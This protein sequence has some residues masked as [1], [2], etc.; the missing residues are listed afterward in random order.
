MNSA[1][2]ESS[3]PLKASNLLR[4]SIY[5]R[6]REDILGCRMAPGEELR[7]QE[8]AVRFEVNVPATSAPPTLMTSPSG[9]AMRTPTVG[10]STSATRAHP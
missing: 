8:L 10:S 2:I 4:D 1:S 7:E 5:T 3:D 9:I 6:L